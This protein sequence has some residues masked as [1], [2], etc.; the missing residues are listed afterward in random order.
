MYSS[1]ERI[2]TW[3]NAYEFRKWP[4]NVSLQRIFYKFGLD[5]VFYQTAMSQFAIFYLVMFVMCLGIV[6]IYFLEDF[7]HLSDSF[8]RQNLAV[9]IYYLPFSSFRGIL[10]ICALVVSVLFI[11][12][13]S[14]MRYILQSELKYKCKIEDFSLMVM[15]IPGHV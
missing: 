14:T 10:W 13:L 2:A 3:R 15:N 12:Y 6:V 4:L 11:R 1:K 8:F 7:T 5:V 9:F